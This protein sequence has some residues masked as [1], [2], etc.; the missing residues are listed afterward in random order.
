MAGIK[1]NNYW[2]LNSPGLRKMPTFDVKTLQAILEGKRE[3][4][5][6]FAMVAA[7][8]NIAFSPEAATKRCQNG[9]KVQILKH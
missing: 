8:K 3:E 6:P 5:L 4:I 2:S 9:R 7:F 1:K